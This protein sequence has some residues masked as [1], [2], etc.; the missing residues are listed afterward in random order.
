MSVLETCLYLNIRHCKSVGVVLMRQC[1]EFECLL[2]VGSGWTICA[3]K[4]IAIILT[5]SQLQYDL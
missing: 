1:D 5:I 4:Y 3:K 2:V